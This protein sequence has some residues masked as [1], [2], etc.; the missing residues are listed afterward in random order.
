MSSECDLEAPYGEA[1]PQNQA[2]A[3]GREGG[4]WGGVGVLRS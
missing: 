1:M 4:R 2:E 3:P